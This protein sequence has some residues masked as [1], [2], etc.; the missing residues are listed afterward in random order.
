MAEEQAQEKT[1]DPTAK[2]KKDAREKGTVLRSREL[3]STV[4]LLMGSIGLMFFGNNLF[5]T[6][7]A[8]MKQSFDFSQVVFN[9]PL[10]MLQIFGHSVA[11]V[12]IAVLPILLIFL[13][14]A[15]VGS[16]AL[17]GFNFSLKSMMPKLEKLSPLKGVKRM[18]SAKSVAEL[19]K[20]LLKFLLVL[21]FSLTFLKSMFVKILS[22]ED[23][24]V[25]RGIFHGLSILGSGF[26]II[27]TAMIVISLIDIPFQIWDHNKKLKMTDQEI[28][29]EMKET[30]GKPEVK[31]K[32]RQLQQSI[33]QRRMMGEIEKANVVLIN[34]EHYSVA[35]YYDKD[36]CPTPKVVAK[37]VDFVA[38]KIREVAN[39]HDVEIVSSP[40][41]ARSLYYTTKLKQEI[42]TGLYMAVAQVLAYVYQLKRFNGGMAEKPQSVEG[43]EIPEE[44]QHD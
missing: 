36:E 30:E 20:A 24:P 38:L 34:P 33:A 43:L 1:R 4:L 8:A 12:S 16:V 35:L 40:V 27:S 25:S 29:D 11:H 31:G 26:I 6:I 32:I 23:E 39:K 10:T 19:V 14:A 9:E 13:V 28:K 15:V 22:L 2:R 18:F 21:A 44:L 37:G 17:G 41:L 7:M 42:P 3:N 5:N